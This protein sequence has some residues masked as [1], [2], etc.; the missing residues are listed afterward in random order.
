MATY[1][2]NAIYDNVESGKS[3]MET[4]QLGRFLKKMYQKNTIVHK[5]FLT[6]YVLS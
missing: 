1:I 3:M 4:A 2:V 6:N 5:S